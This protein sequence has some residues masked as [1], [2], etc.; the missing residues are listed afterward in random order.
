MRE[1]IEQLLQK[2]TSAEDLCTACA[3]QPI[4]SEDFIFLCEKIAN[5]SDEITDRWEQFL[6]RNDSPSPL[7][8][9]F[10]KII[11]IV[12][13]IKVANRQ[14]Q[15]A[16]A[17]HIR[18]FLFLLKQNSHFRT[19]AMHL[20]CLWHIQFVDVSIFLAAKA[21]Y[22]AELANPIIL[23]YLSGHARLDILQR[24]LLASMLQPE[25]LAEFINTRPEVPEDIV[26]E[27]YKKI[28]QDFTYVSELIQ[29]RKKLA[30]ILF[31]HQSKKSENDEQRRVLLNF[32]VSNMGQ[33]DWD[34]LAF[35]QTVLALIPEALPISP[36]HAAHILE[37]FCT[38]S[39]ITHDLAL[40][41]ESLFRLG[42]KPTIFSLLWTML[43][44]KEHDQLDAATLRRQLLIIAIR[45]SPAQ[46]MHIIEPLAIEQKVSLFSSVYQDC[47]RHG[48]Q[49]HL[50]WFLKN[51]RRS[52]FAGPHPLPVFEQLAKEIF[53][54]EK[55]DIIICLKAFFS[56]PPNT[57]S[58]AV[59]LLAAMLRL[60]PQHSDSLST[61]F[62]PICTAVSDDLSILFDNLSTQQAI[63]L[64][65]RVEHKIKPEHFAKVFQRLAIPQQV[66]LLQNSPPS[67]LG[68]YY[69]YALDRLPSSTLWQ[70]TL[71][72]SPLICENGRFTAIQKMLFN[73]LAKHIREDE[74]YAKG[75]WIQSLHA[76][77]FAWLFFIH[78]DLLQAAWSPSEGLGEA[79]PWFNLGYIVPSLLSSGLNKPSKLF[80]TDILECLDNTK[81]FCPEKLLAFFMAYQHES[82]F[83]ADYFK[84][85]K[86]MVEKTSG[87]AAKAVK[88]FVATIRGLD[89]Q[90]HTEPSPIS[91]D[92][93]KISLGNWSIKEHCEK[94]IKTATK[95]SLDNWSKGRNTDF[96]PVHF[97]DIAGKDFLALPIDRQW[98]VFTQSHTLVDLNSNRQKLET[99]YRDLPDQ[100][101]ESLQSYVFGDRSKLSQSQYTDI[102][103]LQF[104]FFSSIPQ[105]H[106]R[107]QAADLSTIRPALSLCT[108]EDMLDLLK[109]HFEQ[110]NKNKPES[111]AEIL[112]L[113]FLKADGQVNTQQN[114]INFAQDAPTL[115]RLG[116]CFRQLSES[117]FFA[118]S[119]TLICQLRK[120]SMPERQQFIESMVSLETSD[121]TNVWH[122]LL[123]I[124]EL[125][126]IQVPE[127]LNGQDSLIRNIFHYLYLLFKRQ[128]RHHRQE[129]CAF[130]MQQ[131]N[132]ICRLLTDKDPNWFAKLL[133]YR[134]FIRLGKR[135]L[136][137]TTIPQKHLHPLADFIIK[138]PLTHGDRPIASDLF[139][140]EVGQDLLLESILNNPWAKEDSLLQLSALLRPE[141]KSGLL[142]KLFESTVISPAHE[143]LMG[144]LAQNLPIDLILKPLYAQTHTRVAISCIFE[145]PQI[146]GLS[147]NELKHIWSLAQQWYLLSKFLTS[148]LPSAQKNRVV[149]LF[150]KTNKDELAQ[151]LLNHCPGGADFAWLLA[152][153]DNRL[154]YASD[155]LEIIK[156]APLHCKYVEAFLAGPRPTS[157]HVPIDSALEVLIRSHFLRFDT[158]APLHTSFWTNLNQDDLAHTLP[159]IKTRMRDGLFFQGI[160]AFV[161][162]HKDSLN[163]TLQT[164]W[165]WSDL[166]FILSAQKSWSDLGPSGRKT[167]PEKNISSDNPWLFLGDARSPLLAL[168]NINSMLDKHV[169]G[170]S[171][172][173]FDSIKTKEN[174][175]K[176]VL[177]DSTV[178]FFN[179]GGSLHFGFRINK[180]P[181]EFSLETL[182][183]KEKQY[184]QE[185]TQLYLSQLKTL[186]ALSPS[187]FNTPEHMDWFIGEFLPGHMHHTAQITCLEPAMLVRLDLSLAQKSLIKLS[188]KI[189]STSYEQAFQ[190]LKS[191]KSNRDI[192]M[193]PAE[194]LEAIVALCNSLNL[195]HYAKFFQAIKQYKLLRNISIDQPSLFL[196][197]SIDMTDDILDACCQAIGET[198]R[199][200]TAN[201]REIQCW[202][203]TPGPNNNAIL[204]KQFAYF[205]AFPSALMEADTFVRLFRAHLQANTKNGK[206]ILTLLQNYKLQHPERYPSLWDSLTPEDKKN[207][208]Q[209]ICQFDSA[210]FFHQDL[211]KFFKA[212]FLVSLCETASYPIENTDEAWEK[213]AQQYMWERIQD[214]STAKPETLRALGIIRILSP[215]SHILRNES[216]RNKSE[217]ALL[218]HYY[219]ALSAAKYHANANP[220][221]QKGHD[222]EILFFILRRYLLTFDGDELCKYSLQWFLR[223]SSLNSFKVFQTL[224]EQLIQENLLEKFFIFFQTEKSTPE[225]AN[226]ILQHLP[227][228]R[229]EL[230][231]ALFL[232]MPIAFCTRQQNNKKIT[233]AH[234]ATKLN[235]LENTLATAKNTRTFGEK[236]LEL[237]KEVIHAF[238]KTELSL[239]ECQILL[240]KT[241]SAPTM[242]GVLLSYL[243]QNTGMSP[244]EFLDEFTSIGSAWDIRAVPDEYIL[245][246]S[247]PAKLV[248]LCNPIMCLRVHPDIISGWLNTPEMFN[249]TLKFWLGKLADFPELGRLLL[250]L[251][252]KQ[253]SKLFK[254]YPHKTEAILR[255]LY[256]ALPHWDIHKIEIWVEYCRSNPPTEHQLT[257]L[258]YF[259][260]S[261]RHIAVRKILLAIIPKLNLQ[262]FNDTACLLALYD[263]CREN[264]TNEEYAEQNNALALTCLEKAASLG[265]L[266]P[267]VKN[268]H[269]LKPLFQ[270]PCKS[271]STHA[272]PILLAQKFFENLCIG[273][274]ASVLQICSSFLQT[275]EDS[276]ALAI[277]LHNPRVS[278]Q[279]K[280]TLCEAI[281]CFPNS[282]E[283]ALTEVANCNHT[284]LF[285]HCS[286]RQL[287][288]F[289]PR[290][291]S[292]VDNQNTKRLL[293]QYLQE[294]QGYKYIAQIQGLFKSLRQW[295]WRCWYFGFTGLFRPNAPTLYNPDAV[296]EVSLNSPDEHDTSFS[297][298]YP[299][300]WLSAPDANRHKS[301][302]VSEI[303]QALR[304]L[305]G[306][307]ALFTKMEEMKRIDKDYTH[308]RRLEA[309]S[310]IIKKWLPE[311][312]DFFELNRKRL[313]TLYLVNH[314]E[315]PP[316]EYDQ[317]LDTWSIGR[318]L[319]GELKSKKEGG[320][321]ANARGL[322]GG[323]LG[324]AKNNLT[325]GT[326]PRLNVPN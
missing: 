118:L 50:E 299:W 28:G 251:N 321:I 131:L 292:R 78:S 166:D 230:Q 298:E 46:L 27:L 178:E 229:P 97:Q 207:L 320:V 293:E 281:A 197:D 254:Q 16:H 255:A 199:I 262:T 137:Q 119:D 105:I 308:L 277:H 117:A 215:F 88:N 33:Y 40:L 85:C 309:S 86:E 112:S 246:L 80:G 45:K 314:I 278:T 269:L 317:Y 127:P 195:Y 44:K 60:N 54:L 47:L 156:N 297:F 226:W 81:Q 59:T 315:I 274:A 125:A 13:C 83:L 18:Q 257:K 103:R 164:A 190:K 128:E 326:I 99:L 155:V 273:Y 223:L 260:Q 248:L 123:L 311:Y 250:I 95:I 143:N 231:E 261:S 189:W 259:Y 84:F 12:N 147:D 74:S 236:A 290:I 154:P 295:F 87:D 227:Q 115:M 135:W 228:E 24:T 181:Q 232:S 91:L 94:L 241:R 204:E 66:A 294:L 283:A 242:H 324:S 220:I 72:S 48:G 107:I 104:H 217:N 167:I 177:S 114:L 310:S 22:V 141:Y 108:L 247:I 29:S 14:D 34:N 168:S 263:F 312:R 132:V 32:V 53:A 92:G 6:K 305:E 165:W 126:D 109:V 284:K 238:A 286:D 323:V 253:L 325:Q 65:M 102:T 202:L 192:I 219:L 37:A 9:L 152:H 150:V 2:A 130:I 173:L 148:P 93:C 282:T 161:S 185:Q 206:D 138:Y 287:E 67:L 306:N 213:K 151:N 96:V 63:E 222:D 256:E 265:Q 244:I 176:R 175:I 56:E 110:W 41:A 124:E 101:A 191:C 218:R 145:H 159:I 279:V 169:P 4:S 144:Y 36:Q 203:F 291:I 240:E 210:L 252:A 64:L 186:F 39:N 245:S 243:F 216:D 52:I 58:Q 113:C 272:R 158:R 8:A 234:L 266:E 19:D 77:P 62:W 10:I 43:Q 7:Q 187:C 198:R 233:I 188:E 270:Q 71:A 319:K 267:L 258:L 98:Q 11:E 90:H 68:E 180:L 25:T 51:S 212:E 303:R 21:H 76:G 224:W 268:P 31:I 35:Y 162:E 61:Y 225:Q 301:P 42:N 276:N 38:N 235:Q 318:W 300:E 120:L 296:K 23:A 209:L 136:L 133:E 111:A 280:E 304:K 182:I 153:L 20:L 211:R 75:A 146:E 200:A 302:N 275:A 214:G 79:R 285:S 322:F 193:L 249:I 26:D 163:K 316:Q 157:F 5:T 73:R 307:P 49:N 179:W 57:S 121:D 271:E 70:V 201:L 15:K 100:Q 171:L 149:A 289:L 288:A 1:M 17:Q 82:N 196:R 129:N 134:D 69:Q 3:G 208:A 122:L 264:L 194:I 30:S 239:D 170:M 174:T 89:N 142:S 55:Q 205:K 106:K 313:V 116:N 221:T 183:S 172:D 160:L 237:G 139:Q 140:S 184:W